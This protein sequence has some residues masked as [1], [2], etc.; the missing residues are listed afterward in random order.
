MMHRAWWQVSQPNRYEKE[1][2]TTITVII[3]F[4]NEASNVIA[5][6]ESLQAQ[7]Y[8]QSLVT[9]LWIDDH[10]EDEGVARLKPLIEKKNHFRLLQLFDTQG[11]KAA[12]RHGILHSE[13]ELIVTID[14]D[15]QLNPN[16][17]ETIARHYEYTR[18]DMI[19]LPVM[20]APV[21]NLFGR[22]QQI[23]FFNLTGLTGG[24]A[25]RNQPLMNNGANLCFQR[26]SY[27]QVHD[28]IKYTSTASG[29]DIFLMLAMK[30]SG[31]RIGYYFDQEVIARTPPSTHIKAFLHQRI[32][33]ASKN[34]LIRDWDIY[35]SGAI[36]VGYQFA[37]VISFIACL[38]GQFPVVLFLLLTACKMITDYR[39]TQQVGQSFSV[40]V[41]LWMSMLLSLIYPFYTLLMSILIFLQPVKW[42]G[43]GISLGRK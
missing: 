8:P 38:C 39:F 7:T 4:R 10:S 29:D 21:H 12:I 24:S 31:M 22:L 33:W 40:K 28:R 20:L 37:W 3:P 25:Y 42:K 15:I 14:A 6:F 23:D 19:I 1:S 32:R 36:I 9:Y 43:R 2:A 30:H 26:K 35:R 18:L 27:Q 16:W 34:R 17:L 41:A 5:L 11:K 13:S